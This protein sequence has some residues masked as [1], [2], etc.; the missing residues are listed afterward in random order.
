MNHDLSSI[1]KKIFYFI[2]AAIFYS[3]TLFAASLPSSITYRL[4]ALAGSLIPL[5]VPKRRRIAVENISRALPFMKVHPLWDR[6]YESAEQIARETF[7]NLGR[8]LVE[9][10]RLYHGRGKRII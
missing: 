1:M 9:V 7:K 6:T 8:S 2:H 10:C 3:L 5:L 4:G